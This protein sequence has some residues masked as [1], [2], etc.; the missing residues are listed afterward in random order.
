MYILFLLPVIIFCYSLQAAV[1]TCGAVSRKCPVMWA[2]LL[3]FS[4]LF[5]APD[6]FVNLT[7]AVWPLCTSR[8]FA[9]CSVR[10]VPSV[11]TEQNC[12]A[13]P[14]YKGQSVP[15]TT[16]GAQEGWEGELF[17]CSMNWC[18]SAVRTENLGL[19]LWVC[20]LIFK[21]HS[22]CRA[23]SMLGES[24]HQMV[25]MATSLRQDLASWLQCLWL[26]PSC[27]NWRWVRC[28]YRSP[29]ICKW[30]IMRH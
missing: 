21:Q 15:R 12:G 22:Q 3:S 11:V 18:L 4:P 8:S 1:Q 9:L 25:R 29:R 19:L 5:Y 28:H 30:K 10:P 13:G 16:S 27:C 20:T 24:R 17:T 14:R 2:V 6:C 26:I 7:K 23:P